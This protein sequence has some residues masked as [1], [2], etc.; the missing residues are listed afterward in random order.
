MKCKK[1]RETSELHT[2]YFLAHLERPEH[3]HRDN[4]TFEREKRY[5]T[6]DRS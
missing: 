2:N 6:Q 3:K 1:L 5:F 4:L